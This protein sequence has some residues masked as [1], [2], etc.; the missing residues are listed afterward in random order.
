MEGNIA[1]EVATLQRLSIGQLRQRFAEVFG[2]ATRAG[3]KIWLGESVP[4][5][6]RERPGVL[7]WRFEREC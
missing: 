2:E 5:L 3:N 7:Q 4:R 6:R 1:N